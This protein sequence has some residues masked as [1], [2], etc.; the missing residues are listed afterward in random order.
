M[1][2][3]KNR[4]VNR[5]NMHFG[6]CTLAMNGAGLFFVVFLLKAGVP[7]PFVFGAIALMVTVRFIS[8]PLVL[9]LAPRFGLR[10]LVIF[11]TI[12]FGLQYPI[13]AEVRGLDWML[14][15]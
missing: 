8:R 15:A 11:G 3:L 4:A 2:Y 1:A 9:M 10:A 14:L 6:L 13:I 5:L 12:L 7:T